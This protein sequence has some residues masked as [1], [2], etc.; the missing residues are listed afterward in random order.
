[1]RLTTLRIYGAAIALVFCS[2]LVPVSSLSAPL[3]LAAQA[4]TSPE[5]RKAEADRLLQEGFQQLNAD[6]LQ[7]AIES[8]QAALELFRDTEVRAAFPRES[9]L[10]EEYALGNLG[11]AYDSLGQHQQAVDLHEQALVIAREVGDRDGEGRTLNDLGIAYRNL[12][13]PERAIAVFQEALTIAQATGNP[14]GEGITL[15]NLGNTYANL[16]DLQRAIETY[17]R[18]LTISREIGNRPSEIN[19]LVNLSL[20]YRRL[21]Q[22]QQADQVCAQALTIF[23]EIGDP[24][25]ES[26]CPIE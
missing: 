10:G 12:E 8:W 22:E 19:T 23:R 18:S 9:R 6:Q 17:E 24:T 13:Q 20:A 3:P 26:V 11:V 16:G 5:Q 7:A 21:G 14:V 15:N 2:P 1:M 4:Q 25:A